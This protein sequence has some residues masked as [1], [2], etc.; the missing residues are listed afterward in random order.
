MK[1]SKIL[2]KC[3]AAALCATLFFGMG[4]SAFA[5]DKVDIDTS[6][7]SSYSGGSYGLNGD[8]WSANWQTQD[9]ISIIPARR[10]DSTYGDIT[11]D[12]VVTVDGKKA[13]FVRIDTLSGIDFYIFSA[14]DTSTTTAPVTT[15]VAAT[16]KT[17]EQAYSDRQ[18]DKKNEIVNT[19]RTGKNIDGTKTIEIREG[20]SLSSD[21]M[22]TIADAKD[23]NVQFYFTRGY[24]HFRADITPEAAK[25]APKVEW[26]GPLFLQKYFH[27]TKLD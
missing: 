21:I 13:T 6:K 24:E 23:V 22:E 17:P 7:A 4:L 20:D 8:G 11:A 26:A 5:A 15:Q 18:N 14:K 16:V 12:S 19:A 3:S 10:A 9:E 25:K 27:V 2:A 1:R